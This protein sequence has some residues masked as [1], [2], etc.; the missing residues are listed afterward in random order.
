MAVFRYNATQHATTGMTPYRALFGVD[1]FE[2]ACALL[3]RYR[4]D[5][6]PEELGQSM[7]EVDQRLFAR[8]S[9]SRDI[10]GRA[11]DRA[12]REGAFI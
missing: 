5:D 7:K 3:Q 1:V 4:V 9:E 10:A 8:E 12:V 6:E 11:Y 2:F